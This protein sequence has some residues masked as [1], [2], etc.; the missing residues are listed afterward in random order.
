MLLTIATLYAG[1][2]LGLMT[3]GNVR[4]PAI[5]LNP[6][7]DSGLESLQ[8]LQR[9]GRCPPLWPLA[10]M[11]E[12]G[13]VGKATLIESSTVPPGMAIMVDAADFTTAGAEG[14]RMEISDQATL[15]M[16]DT[17]PADIVSGP[18]GT[19]APATPVKSMWQT[20]SLALRMIMKMNWILRRPVVSWMTGV[21]WDG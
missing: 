4:K 7:P 14:P 1:A 10:T 6:I 19:P 2:L 21:A 13:R 16:E 11:I 9:L 3:N 18:S 20:D 5:L 12:Q 8:P 15:H 17:A